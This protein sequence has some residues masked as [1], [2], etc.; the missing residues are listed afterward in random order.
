MQQNYWASLSEPHGDRK[1]SP[2]HYSVFK[3]VISVTTGGAFELKVISRRTVITVIAE[4]VVYLPPTS[5][6]KS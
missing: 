4:T 1:A 5:K 3:I 6:T 2:A